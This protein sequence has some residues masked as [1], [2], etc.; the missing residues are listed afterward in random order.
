MVQALY[1]SQSRIEDA[2]QG[3]TN[4]GKSQTGQHQQAAG[5]RTQ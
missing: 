5:S 3:K 2:V 1:T 4:H